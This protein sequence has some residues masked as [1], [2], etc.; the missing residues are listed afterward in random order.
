MPF[1]AGP[2]RL[3]RTL[4]RFFC[5]GA[6]LENLSALDLRL[7]LHGF[8]EVIRNVEFDYFGHNNFRRPG[9]QDLI[10]FTLP[11]K[12]LDRE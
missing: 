1:A 4:G 8:A 11:E 12:L 10:A 5:R 3:T 2:I 6:K 9:S 7:P